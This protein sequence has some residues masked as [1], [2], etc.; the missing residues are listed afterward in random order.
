MSLIDDKELN[1]NEII[2]GNIKGYAIRDYQLPINHIY[3]N[4]HDRKNKNVNEKKYVILE[5][6]TSY[7][8]KTV[9]IVILV[10]INKYYILFF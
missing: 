9:F 7:L 4:M 6:K 5:K 2:K 1:I 3:T 10:N 8:V